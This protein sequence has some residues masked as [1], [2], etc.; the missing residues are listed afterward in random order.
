MDLKQPLPVASPGDM[1]QKTDAVLTDGTDLAIALIASSFLDECLRTLL[2]VS[3]RDGDRSVA[4]L[5][6]GRGVLGTYGARLDLAY[7][8]RLIEKAELINLRTV[9]EI[10]NAFAHSFTEGAFDHEPIASLCMNLDLDMAKLQ[11]D[12]MTGDSER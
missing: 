5:R 2:W 8:L 3:F 7:S 12:R 10:R 6:S 4:Q 11:F 1:V 9:G